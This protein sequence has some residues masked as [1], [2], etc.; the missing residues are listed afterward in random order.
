[1]EPLYHWACMFLKAWAPRV[2]A[3]ASRVAEALTTHQVWSHCLPTSVMEL[4][5]RVLGFSVSPPRCDLAGVVAGPG[6]PLGLGAVPCLGTP[7]SQCGWSEVD[8]RQG[9]RDGQRV[10]ARS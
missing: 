4:E 1:M 9:V 5:A 2:A 6:M 3:W 8:D 7:G 10:W